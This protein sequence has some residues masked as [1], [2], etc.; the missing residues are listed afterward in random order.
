MLFELIR[1]L[2]CISCF[3]F[4]SCDLLSTVVLGASKQWLSGKWE[5]PGVLPCGFM[6]VSAGRVCTQS[7]WM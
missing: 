2:A 7:P 1:T 4:W 3:N 6:V 5:T